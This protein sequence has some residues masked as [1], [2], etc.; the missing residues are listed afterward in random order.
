[1]DDRGGEIGDEYVDS[2][3]VDTDLQPGMIVVD[4]D[5]D[6]AEQNEAV[7]M[8]TPPVPAEQWDVTALDCTLAEANP[9]YP[10]DAATVLVIYRSRFDD[11]DEGY[12]VD[13]P[14][15]I[16]RKLAAHDEIAVRDVADLCKFYAFP[17]PRLEPTGEYWPP[18]SAEDDPADVN[19]PTTVDTAAGDEDDDDELARPESGGGSE[20]PTGAPADNE[21]TAIDLGRLAT[22]MREAGFEEV[23]QDGDHV[24]ATKLGETYRVDHTG[25]VT[26]GGVL[27]DKLASF[28][29]ERYVQ[30]A[31][32]DR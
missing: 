21:E 22:V 8:T 13:V 27:A 29:E 1:M 26:E 12:H 16:R 20:E 3:T 15:E 11:D 23:V 4:R 5:Q 2:V 19:T 6:E 25:D 10:A 28:V 32:A 24:R 30:D 17:E 7:V 14:D 9:D 18:S 31:D